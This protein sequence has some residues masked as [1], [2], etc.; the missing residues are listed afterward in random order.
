[1]HKMTLALR[2][3]VAVAPQASIIDDVPPHV[4]QRS[5]AGTKERRNALDAREGNRG[6]ASV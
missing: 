6:A 2:T 3:T 1:M 4:F 5:T